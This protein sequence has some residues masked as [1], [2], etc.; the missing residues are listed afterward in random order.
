VGVIPGKGGSNRSGSDKREALNIAMSI[1]TTHAKILLQPYEFVSDFNGWN[2]DKRMI[3]WR[4]KS[5]ILQTLDDV[6]P[7]K[8]ETVPDDDE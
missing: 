1:M 3:K 6:T 5:P 7:S 2:N 8:R 4:F